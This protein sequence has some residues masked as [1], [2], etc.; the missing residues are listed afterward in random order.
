MPLS[1]PSG[2]ARARSAAR[3]RPVLD[4]SVDEPGRT[5]GPPSQPLDRLSS[6]IRPV[7]EHVG[8]SASPA[9]G[10]A[11]RQRAHRRFL[12]LPCVKWPAPHFGQCRK[13][14]IR[15][16]CAAIDWTCLLK[17]AES[18]VSPLYVVTHKPENMR[19]DLKCRRLV[20]LGTCHVSPHS[21]QVLASPCGCHGNRTRSS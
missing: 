12:Y 21:T 9:A 3:R 6:Q 18:V 17:S 1:T 2:R 20:P 4:F 19:S 8:A 7:R 16:F 5:A 15:W 13:A 14:S 11:H 10:V